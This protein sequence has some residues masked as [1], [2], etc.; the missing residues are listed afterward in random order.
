VLSL[1]LPPSPLHFTGQNGFL[2]TFFLLAASLHV[3]ELTV[4]FNGSVLL[5]SLINAMERGPCSTVCI[6]QSQ[7]ICWNWRSGPTT[8]SV[9]A[10]HLCFVASYFIAFMRQQCTAP[11]CRHCRCSQQCQYVFL[12]SR[13]G[14]VHSCSN[15]S[16]KGSNTFTGSRLCSTDAFTPKRRVLP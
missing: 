16:V 2:G 13:Q 8:A 14:V 3:C 5:C 15:T 4:Q 11:S 9:F 6:I 1:V 10:P 12:N 7:R